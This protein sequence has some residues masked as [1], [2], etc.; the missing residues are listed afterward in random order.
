MKGLERRFLGPYGCSHQKPSSSGLIGI[1][2]AALP[3]VCS[4]PSECIFSPLATCV[5]WLNSQGS[6]LFRNLRVQMPMVLRRISSSL[7]HPGTPPSIQSPLDRQNMVHR[8]LPP[9]GLFASF[10]TWL[11]HCPVSPRKDVAYSRV[12][13]T[14]CFPLLKEFFSASCGF[15]GTSVFKL[16]LEF[17]PSPHAGPLLLASLHPCPLAAAS[18][19]LGPWLCLDALCSFNIRA[20][21]LQ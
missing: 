1:W 19:P 10:C 3:L 11:A 7:K 2:P 15:L 5:A 9:L 20:H 21:T 14:S 16:L 8:S 4:V 18:E 12:P 13:W 17:D 6:M